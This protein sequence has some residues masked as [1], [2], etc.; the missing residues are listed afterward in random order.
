MALVEGQ[1]IVAVMALRQHK[2]REQAALWSDQDSGRQFV[3]CLPRIK[4][5]QEAARIDQDHGSPKPARCLSTCSAKCGSALTKIGI[6]GAGGDC[7]A[8]ARAMPSRMIAAAGRPV[9]A[10]TRSNWAFRSAGK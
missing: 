6:V 3:I 5:G 10:A 9:S 8:T 1:Q 2:G 7:C 4:R